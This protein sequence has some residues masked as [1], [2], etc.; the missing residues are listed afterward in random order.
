MRTEAGR[1]TRQVARWN[2]SEALLLCVG[3][4]QYEVL[5]MTRMWICF[6]QSCDLVLSVFFLEALDQLSRS[7][8]RPHPKRTARG[9]WR[10]F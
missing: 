4:L 3:Y 1:L 8:G 2:H 10:V 7:L 6:G 9:A 5:I